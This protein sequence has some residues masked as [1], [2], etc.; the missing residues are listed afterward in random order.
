MWPI[1]SHTCEVTNRMALSGTNFV[2]FSRHAL[3]VIRHHWK[4][5]G[6]RFELRHFALQLR[7]W[8]ERHLH[9]PGMLFDHTFESIK[10]LSGKG[11]YELRIDDD[12]GGQ[13]NIRIVF[14]D[15]PASW[16]PLDSEVKPM[17]SIWILE[18]LPKRRNDWSVNDL[19]RFKAA[20][21]VIARR[22]YGKS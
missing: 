22:F 9:H 18:A 2:R 7:W 19:T 10:A 13:H 11:I 15:P 8:D 14:F 12:V 1:I 20:R 4:V 3:Q 16:Q 5:T 6:D 17:R 21:L